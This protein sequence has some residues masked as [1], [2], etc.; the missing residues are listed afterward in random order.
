MATFPPR[1]RDEAPR[2]PPR[3]LHLRSDVRAAESPVKAAHARATLARSTVA[4]GAWWI[5]AS[6]LALVSPGCERGPG[7]SPSRRALLREAAE[8]SGLR[9]QHHAYPSEARY[10]PEIMGA[11]CALFDKDGDGDLDLYTVQGAPV[12][13]S[14][15]RQGLPSS[16]LHENLVLDAG[17]SA[18]GPLRFV[19][20]TE[21][22]GVGHV[23]CGTGAAAGDFDGDGDLDLYLTCAGPNV[24]FQND[25]GGRFSDVTT[26]ARVTAGGFST[27]AAWLDYDQD[28][29]LDLFV[30]RYVKFTPAQNRRCTRLGGQPDYCGP[31]SYEPETSLL[32]RNEGGGRFSDASERS[33]VATRSGNGLGALAADLDGD[34]WVDIF[35]AND[36][37]PNHLW[38]NLKNGR[39]EERGLLSGC[40]LSA[41]GLSL[42][43]MG[44]ALG[45]LDRDGAPDL[46]VTHEISE[47]NVAY[48]GSAGGRF[49]DRSAAFGLAAGSLPY[50]GFG[51]LSLDLDL[52]GWLDLVVSN[53]AVRALAAQATS[54]WPYRQP[55][56]LYRNLGG[57]FV[58]ATPESG[59]NDGGEESG[60]GSACGDL[61]LDGDLDLVI[62]N[63]NGPLRLFLN[64]SP[65]KGRLLR[66][67]LRC[68]GESAI[69]ASC[70]LG[71]SAG[72]PL[73]AWVASGGS[74]LS[75]GPEIVYF[76]CPDGARPLECEVRWPR[77][78]VKVYPWPGEADAAVFEKEGTP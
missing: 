54:P 78:K 19:D 47:P 4:R 41:D 34:G 65:R 15:S 22:A 43:G 62:T 69:G 57:H 6:L 29:N 25:G 14:R 52:D 13:P 45:D 32:Y 7:T 74:Y 75:S 38:I 23:G 11:G 72:P 58:E 71:L 46:Y 70:T 30:A 44:I 3:R 37:T 10:L 76:G 24:L 8:E 17:Q 48:R 2:P 33:G 39:F 35:V 26:Q 53:G 27:S 31:V 20:V 73:C 67:T 42:A 21:R 55:D 51:A 49:E 64:E 61:D 16:L 66:V 63:A 60:R 5:C 56:Q 68:R 9:V 36:A 59:L 40:A 18:P 1:T 12:D 50:S 77:G 28:G